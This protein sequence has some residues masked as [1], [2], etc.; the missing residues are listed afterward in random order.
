MTVQELINELNDVENKELPVFIYQCDDIFEINMVD[1][2]IS[3]RVDLNVEELPYRY[4]W[5]K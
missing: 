1:L 2:T 4:D 3:D 5:E